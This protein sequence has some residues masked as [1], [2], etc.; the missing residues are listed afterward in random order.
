M[1]QKATKFKIIPVD[2]AMKRPKAS[3]KKNIE[4]YIQVLYHIVDKLVIGDEI[5]Y[6][7]N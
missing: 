2:Y 3:T 1:N 7:F 5:A 6:L 4:W